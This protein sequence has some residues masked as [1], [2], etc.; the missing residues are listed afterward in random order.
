MEVGDVFEECQEL[1]SSRPDIA[2]YF[3][4]R[5]ANKCAHLIARAP[6]LV[7]CHHVYVSPPNFL[8]ENL[9]YDANSS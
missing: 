7:D 2:L 5:Q 1:L 8:L 4:K 9:L 3:V 6:C